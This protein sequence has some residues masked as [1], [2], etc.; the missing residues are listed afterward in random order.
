MEVRIIKATEAPI[1]SIE[2]VIDL[3]VDEVGEIVATGPMVTRTYDRLPKATAGAKIRDGDRIWHRMGDLGRLDPD[4]YLWFCGRQ[5]EAVRTDDAIFYTDC[6]EAVFNQ[7]REVRRT[8]L[9]AWSGKGPVVPAMVVEPSRK[10]LMES[11]AARERLVAELR[12]LA[13]SVP[14]TAAIR[15]FFFHPSFP[16]DVRHNAKIHRLSLTRQFARKKPIVI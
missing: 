2:A 6:C 4:G 7:H 14:H 15:H 9:I 16:V 10:S 3:P 11:P 1:E 13:Q 5:A 12:D 8:A